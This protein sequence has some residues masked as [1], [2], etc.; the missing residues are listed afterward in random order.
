M[1]KQFLR[2]PSWFRILIP[3][4]LLISILFS[5]SSFSDNG[6]YQSGA[7][8]AAAIFFSAYGIKMR[9]NFTTSIIFFALAVLC[10][11]LSWHNFELARH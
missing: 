7:K 2:E 6:Y 5:T 8:V 10:I 1:F 9:R 3:V 4:T 11:Y